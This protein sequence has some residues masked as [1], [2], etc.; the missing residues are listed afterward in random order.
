MGGR[1]KHAVIN[2]QQKHPILLSPKCAFSKLLIN[3]AHIRCNHG[4]VQLTT[5]TLRQRVWIIHGRN[6]IRNTLFNCITCHRFRKHDSN[7]LMSALPGYRVQACRPFTNI[8][9]DYAGPIELKAS[10]LRSNKTYKVYIAL[11]IC[12]S[13]KAVHLEVVC[14]LK[15]DAF[16]ATFNRFIG[17]RGLPA[18][19]YSYFVGAQ[20]KLNLSL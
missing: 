14:E 6:K 15:T 11:F 17:R 2:Y 5:N 16:I 4:G 20:R 19:V 9:V 3:D 18:N 10:K 1:I 13:T 7:Q 12:L 8:G